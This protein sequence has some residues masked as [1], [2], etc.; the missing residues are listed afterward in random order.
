MAGADAGAEIRLSGI[1]QGVGFRPFVYRLALRLGLRGSVRNAGDAVVVVAVGP[2]AALD[3]FVQ[4]VRDEAPPLARIEAFARRSLT[5]QEL[6][7]WPGEAGFCIAE[8]GAG[9]VSVGV[10]PDV[11]TCPAC[12]AE[13]ADPRARRFRYAFTNCT[14]CGPR[15]SIVTGL[16]YDRPATTMAGF[17]L[18]PACAAEYADPADRR[19]HAQPIACPTC[20]PRVWLERVDDRGGAG[21]IVDGGVPPPNPPPQAGEGLYGGAGAGS[22]RSSEAVVS[23]PASPGGASPSPAC[24]GGPG[25]GL[26]GD[27]G[28]R[29][30]SAVALPAGE[31]VRV[32]MADAIGA[33]AALLRAGRIVAV[34]GIGGFHIACDAT[35]AAAVANLRQRKRRPSKPLAVMAD[36]ARAE[37]LCEIGPA[38]AAALEAPSA[39][40]VLLPLKEG[41][42]LAPEIA[43]GQRQVG[44]MLPY[45]PL[46]HLLMEAVGRP[47]VMTSGN[48]SGVP[49]VIANEEARAALA[50]IVDGFLMHDRPIA[51]R[52][53][54]SVVRLAAGA[55]R[56]M[57]RG[58]GLAPLPLTLPE[59]FAGAPPVLALGAELKSAIC[60]THG[61]KALLSHHLGDLDEPGTIDAFEAAIADYAAMFAHVPA[62]VAVDAHPGYHATRF[63][64]AWAAQRGVPLEVVQHHH[65]HMAA[66]MAEA[67]WRRA[68]GPVVAILLDGLGLGEDGTLWGAEIFM[69]DYRSARRTARLAPIALMGGDQASR[70]PWRVLLAHLDQALGRTA[71]DGDPQLAALFAGKPLATLRAMADK[72][73]NAPHASSAGRLFDAVAALLGL[74]PD[75]LSHEGEAAMALEAVAASAAPYPLAVTERDGLW[76]LDPAPLWRALRADQAAGRPLSAMAGAFHAGLAAAFAETAIL[77]ARR[78]GIG[79][80]AVAGGVFQNR[81]L[82]EAV[83]ARLADAG[84]RPLVPANVPANDGGLAL[85]QAVVAA[86]RHI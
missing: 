43:P 45:T 50:H 55:P 12:R 44:V 74:A 60:L 20:G 71:V 14:D 61:A 8:S 64:T 2:A 17:P 54:D 67:G 47:L 42:G 57:R 86:A 85:G 82:L 35:D 4:G 66:A 9:A 59:D 13:I 78:E 16:P 18:C 53:D 56:V 48:S 73:L 70:E 22:G 38:E 79:A 51:R 77:I 31:G 30:E 1:V 27:E 39:P 68:D 11:A 63:G 28:E 84:L 10:V 46:H 21:A 72:G 49:Q 24:G 19:F 26:A 5:A 76:A 75:R 6:A 34:K 58:R 62:R 83:V 25:R 41:H 7:L 15:F 36:R 37:R 81:M 29:S 33:A 65:A 80:V 32:G 3:A 40:I 69:G 23:A 52:L